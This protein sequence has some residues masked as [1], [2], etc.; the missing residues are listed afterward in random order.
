MQQHVAHQSNVASPTAKR[1]TSNLHKGGTH[2]LAANKF[3]PLRDED[4]PLNEDQFQQLPGTLKKS[5][6]MMEIQDDKLQ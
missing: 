1:S 2:D 6:L 4:E 3:L 5:Y